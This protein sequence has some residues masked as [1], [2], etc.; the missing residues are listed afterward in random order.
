MPSVPLVVSH[1][2]VRA[3]AGLGRSP[4]AAVARMSLPLEKL[5]G[6]LPET[7][8]RHDGGLPCVVLGVRCLRIGG[9]MSEPRLLLARACMRAR[10]WHVH[11]EVS[12][13]VRAPL[14][15]LHSG[16]HILTLADMTVAVRCGGAPCNCIWQ[17]RPS[18]TKRKVF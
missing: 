16:A 1:V 10:P 5:A 12:E 15:S 2:I 17:P 13:E 11:G 3:F 18:G 6:A 14:R 8:Q 4:G 9:I 7:M